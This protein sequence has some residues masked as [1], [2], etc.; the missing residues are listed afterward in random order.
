MTVKAETELESSVWKE[1]NSTS[2]K[3]KSSKCSESV[4]T[5]HLKSS[6]V[7]MTKQNNNNKKGCREKKKVN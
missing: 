6:V 4:L 2:N 3:E 1:Q 7:F 5:N